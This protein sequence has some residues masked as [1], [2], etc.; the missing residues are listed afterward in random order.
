MLQT[1]QFPPAKP[2][3]HQP[4]QRPAGARTP[5]LCSSW[6]LLLQRYPEQFVILAV[7]EKLIANLPL[8]GLHLALLTRVKT[9]P[10]RWRACV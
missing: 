3:Q 8:D 1:G 6:E 9:R 7:L 2:G 4:D 5:L 10:C